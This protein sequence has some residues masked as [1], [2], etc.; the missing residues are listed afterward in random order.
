M[1]NMKEDVITLN[2]SEPETFTNII[3]T[4]SVTYESHS[5]PSKCNAILGTTDDV[6]VCIILFNLKGIS[7]NN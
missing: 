7:A 2:G 4:T 1:S 6:K 3:S 5:E